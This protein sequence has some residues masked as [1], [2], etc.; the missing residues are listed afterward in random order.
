[1]W[2][3]Q[4]R[5]AGHWITLEKGFISESGAEWAA[6]LWKQTN[7]CTGHPFRVVLSQEGGS[8]EK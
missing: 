8:T 2:E 4:I 1:M 5:W 3:I 7:N 6:A